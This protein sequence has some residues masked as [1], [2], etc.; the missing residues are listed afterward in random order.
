MCNVLE[1]MQKRKLTRTHAREFERISEDGIEHHKS[2]LHLH[3]K[4]TISLQYARN[5]LA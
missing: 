5:F 1:D 3:I 4:I 2:D